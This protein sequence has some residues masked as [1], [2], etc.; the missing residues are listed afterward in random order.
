MALDNDVVIVTG[1]AR[2]IGKALV[3]ELLSRNVKK[4]YAV[5]RNETVKAAYAGQPEI[6]ALIADVSDAKQVAALALI[7][8]DVTVVINNAG[9]LDF[10]GSLTA[11]DEAISRNFGTNFQGQLNVARSFAP[12]MEK[13]GGGHLVNLLTV[14]S[15]ASMP[16]LAVYNASKAAAWSMTQSLRADLAKKGI[17]VHA[18]FP[19]PVDTDMAAEITFP[20]TSPADVAEAIVEGIVN[21]EEDIFPD[22]MSKQVY[23]AWRADHKAV[24]KQFAS[25]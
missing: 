12:I 19:G 22:E 6:T 9:V 21:G 2:G 4:I 11:S 13:N 7:A 23:A 20:K 10:G 3:A 5:G 8:P 1:A 18:V 25:M 24:E 17:Q 15:F 16:A 14:V